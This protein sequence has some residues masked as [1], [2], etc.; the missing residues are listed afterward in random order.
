MLMSQGASYKSFLN[1]MQWKT[2]WTLI[3]AQTP[4]WHPVLHLLPYDLDFISLTI[5]PS[6]VKFK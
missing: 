3:A 1:V 6:F 4:I 2:M 5:I